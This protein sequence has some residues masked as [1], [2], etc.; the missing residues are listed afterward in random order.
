VDSMF[1]VDLDRWSLQRSFSLSIPSPCSSTN[2]NATGL[3]LATTHLLGQTR[4]ERQPSKRTAAS[5]TLK[6]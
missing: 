6:K 4:I 2:N 3:K 5:N 1:P